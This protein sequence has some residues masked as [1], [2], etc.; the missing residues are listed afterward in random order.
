MP[1]LEETVLEEKEEDEPI[2]LEDPDLPV[3]TP[4]ENDVPL[5]VPAPKGE[6]EGI[7]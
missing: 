7:F 4:D 6:D 2:N 1:D 5:P 3:V